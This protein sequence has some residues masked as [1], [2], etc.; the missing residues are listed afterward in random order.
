MN[1]ALNSY[2]FELTTHKGELVAI[3]YQLPPLSK[4]PHYIDASVLD[5][6]LVEFICEQEE[7]WSD[8]FTD[9]SIY[10]LVDKVSDQ[11]DPRTAAWLK[12]QAAK[13]EKL[14]AAKSASGLMPTTGTGSL[15]TPSSTQ[16]GVSSE[17]S[18]LPSPKSAGSIPPSLVVTPRKTSGSTTQPAQP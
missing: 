2:D 18:G 12:R 15:P 11:M 10:A 17:S 4:L 8:Q 1:D 9:E 7:G 13:I 3:T 5:S 16:A 6:K 14:K